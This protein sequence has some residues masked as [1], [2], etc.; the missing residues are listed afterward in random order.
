MKR[1]IGIFVFIFPFLLLGNAYALKVQKGTATIPAGSTSI[2][3][4][5]TAVNSL[6]RAFLLMWSTGDSGTDWGGAWQATGY[7]SATNQ[8]TFER[9]ETRDD[10][11]ISWYVWYLSPYLCVWSIYC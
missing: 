2:N 5:I 11:R 4:S 9:V 8:I 7:L 3:V 1:N 6:S 10:C